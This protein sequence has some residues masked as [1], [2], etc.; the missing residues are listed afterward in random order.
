[1]KFYLSIVNIK[2]RKEAGCHAECC[3]SFGKDYVKERVRI[4][5]KPTS[6]CDMRVENACSGLPRPD[7]FELPLRL[8]FLTALRHFRLAFSNIPAPTTKGLDHFRCDCR[9]EGYANEDK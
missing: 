7:L 3:R 4:R 1:V 6:Q 8:R 5:L 9:S 2:Y